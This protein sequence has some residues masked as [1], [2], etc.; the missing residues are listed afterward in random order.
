MKADGAFALLAFDFGLRHIGVAVAQTVTRT[1]RGAATV[2][3]R[4]TR[5]HWRAI[6]QLI[7]EHAPR[8]LL[9]G[10]PLNM[11]D[12]DNH[13]TVAAREFAAALEKRTGLPVHLQ[14]E[15][16]TSKA[17]EE[18]LADARDLGIASTDHELA[19]CYIA[20]DWMRDNLAD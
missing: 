19:A 15:R 9:V 13:V 12:T 20:E 7:D 6:T 5:P 10:L 16:L 11:D 4:G 14:D 18:G 3:Y 17:A 2:G 1:A 8:A